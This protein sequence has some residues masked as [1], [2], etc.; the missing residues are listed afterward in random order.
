MVTSGPPSPS[1]ASPARIGFVLPALN[2]EQAIAKVLDELQPSKF[3]RV[4][5]VDNGSTDATAAVARAH[6]PDVVE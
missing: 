5:V 3:A 1:I 4:V 2:E 6:G